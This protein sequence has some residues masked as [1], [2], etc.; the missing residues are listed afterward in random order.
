MFPFFSLLEGIVPTLTLTSKSAVDFSISPGTA[1]CGFRFNTNG[2]AQTNS[3][4]IGYTTPA[5]NQWMDD[6]FAALPAFDATK[7]ECGLFSVTYGGS[8]SASDLSGPTVDAYHA[9]TT[10]RGW[11]FSKFF[12]GF[13]NASLSG[14]IKLREIANPS[15]EVTASLTLTLTAEL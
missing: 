3:N 6:V 1:T 2:D 12:S 9:L 5:A 14:T 8:G 10:I 11:T 4:G 13:G 15:N 7:Y